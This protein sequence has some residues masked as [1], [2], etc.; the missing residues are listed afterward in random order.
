MMEYDL[1]AAVAS[2]EGRGAISVIRM[3]GKGCFEALDKVFFA[4]NKLPSAERTPREMLMGKI[5]A[6]E[7]LLDEGMCAVFRKPA[8]Y[9]G[10]DAAELFCHGGRVVTSEILSALLTAGCRLARGGEFTERAFLNGKLTLAA[11]E[12]V[13]EI[14]DA[15]NPLYVSTAAANLSGRFGKRIRA[16]RSDLLD[17]AAHYAACLDYA[18]EGVEPPDPERIEELL[19]SADKELKELKK[20]C[21]AGK[22]IR[23]GA[24]VAIVGRTNSG[25]ST[26]LNYV[27]GYERAIV[28]EYAG[29][30]RDVI[31]E[32]VTIPG[33][34]VRFIDTAGFREAD[35]PVE[36]I[37]IEKSREMLSRAEACV[38]LFDGSAEMGEEDLLTARAVEEEKNRRGEL[39][40]L[41]AVNKTDKELKN[42]YAALLPEEKTYFISAETGEGMDE[43]LHALGEAVSG[44]VTDA[45][46]VTNL[47]HRDVI[48]R[49]SE[50]LSATE[51]DRKRGMTDDVVWSGIIS[52]CE[53]LGEIT[54]DTAKEDMI[55]RIFENFCV[56]K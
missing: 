27:L 23:E 51:T 24:P 38:V 5:Y 30:T 33:G 40:I 9:T 45:D 49:A 55:E 46:A 34:A 12:A 22:M 26:F 32:S 50:V 4:K 25:K 48:L 37:G 20:G 39:K 2:P 21:L 36:R 13:E 42:D 47:R 15:N 14:V 54:G 6:G 43:L 35:D 8:S 31:E 18:D 28:T 41:K 29:T 1:I 56:G 7:R 52:A 16:I 19:I 53:I 10:E 17:A 3:S 44:G 11:A